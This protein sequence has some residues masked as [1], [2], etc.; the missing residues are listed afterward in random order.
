MLKRL[1]PVIVVV[2]LL[3]LGGA[4][5]FL[6]SYRP[7][8]TENPDGNKLQDV[9]KE[10]FANLMNNAA[11][12]HQNRNHDHESPVPDTANEPPQSK[13]TLSE[14]WGTRY[15]SETINLLE[16][17]KLVPVEP[18]GDTNFVTRSL[19]G[20]TMA[21]DDYRG[22]WRL[23]NFWATWCAPCRE[24]MPAF[25]RLQEE[26]PDGNFYVLGVNVGES[27]STIQKFVSNHNLDFTILLD[28]SGG[29]G[30]QYGTFTLPETWLINPEGDVLGVVR[31]P[32]KWNRA[33]GKT[34]FEQLTNS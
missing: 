20:D 22:S 12:R 13:A 31:G 14:K 7:G 29:I 34:L 4:Y 11:R 2:L 5:W 21:L 32:R 18:T 26:F 1:T 33:P 16:E 15:D 30:K 10:E 28:Q 19:S 8:F 17:L 6:P 24:E 9:S 25:Q 3:G 23:V 27:Q